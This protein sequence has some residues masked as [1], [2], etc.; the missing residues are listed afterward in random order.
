M[1]KTK[2][3]FLIASIL[4]LFATASFAEHL[5]QISPSCVL[6]TLDGSPAH[7]LQELKGEVVYVDFWASWCPPCVK[8]FS[9]LNQLDHDLKDKGLH[10]I[11]VNLD[12]KIK[13][14]QEFLAKYPANFSI[15]ADSN[16]ECAKVF[17]VMA[18]PTSY[19]IDRK[20]TIRHIHQGFRP[21]ETEELRALI[22]QLVMEH[23]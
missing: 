3:L 21:G 16:K 12:E 7:N 9:F 4:G 14:A 22:T 11:G 17:E 6:T 18:M 10:V 15:V 2:L 13:D 1:K 19:V 23:P 20:G 5:D 8:S